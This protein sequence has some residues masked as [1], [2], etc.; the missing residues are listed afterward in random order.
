MVVN[1]REEEL[2]RVKGLVV[3]VKEVVMVGTWADLELLLDLALRASETFLA[4]FQTF[5]YPLLVWRLHL[6]GFYFFLEDFL[7]FLKV[8]VCFLL[9][10]NHLLTSDK[11]FLWFLLSSLEFLIDCFSSLISLAVSSFISLNSLYC[12]KNSDSAL[13]SFS[14]NSLIVF[15]DSSHSRTL[16]FS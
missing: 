10:F 11:V 3:V 1:G 6:L 8:K 13:S 12:L 5:L 14:S 16:F 4:F 2:S 9:Y 15:L 7:D